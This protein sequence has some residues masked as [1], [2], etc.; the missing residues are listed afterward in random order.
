MLSDGNEPVSVTAEILPLLLQ[1]VTGLQKEV[2][3]YPAGRVPGGLTGLTH[4][5]PARRALMSSPRQPWTVSSG[6]GALWAALGLKPPLFSQS[7]H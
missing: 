7:L 1:E 6:P 5:P 2:V 4:L 3:R